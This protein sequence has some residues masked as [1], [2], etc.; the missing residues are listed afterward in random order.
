MVLIIGVIGLVS[1][2]ALLVVVFRHYDPAGTTGALGLP[3]G[4]VQAVIALAL[5]LI[6]ALFGVYLHG[7]AG[8]PELRQSACLTAGQVSL[9]PNGTVVRA[10]TERWR[11]GTDCTEPPP[12]PT[13]TRPRPPPDATPRQR[14]RARRA[15]QR[16]TRRSAAAAAR[17]TVVRYRVTVAVPNEERN[18][19]TTQLLSIIG[20]LVVAVAGFYFGSKAVQAGVARAGESSRAGAELALLVPGAG[21]T[22][23]GGATGVTERPGG[24]AGGAGGAAEE[25]VDEEVPEGDDE[26]LYGTHSAAGLSEP[27][28]RD[29]LQSAPLAEEDEA[30]DSLD[31]QGAEEPEEGEPEEE[32]LEEEDEVEEPETE[33]APEDEEPP[34][35]V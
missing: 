19:I 2:M 31:E 22:G 15:A 5:I 14:R 33:P 35:K 25:V 32:D 1:V 3:D 26:S 29:E 24:P 12:K 17:N 21:D 7:K 16:A 11:R 8:T 10:E 28:V 34:E 18:N 9:I 23:G 6:F 13:V 27:D 30:E 20:T 4:S